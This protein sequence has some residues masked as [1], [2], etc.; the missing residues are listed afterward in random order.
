MKILQFLA[1]VGVVLTVAVPIAVVTYFGA[2]LFI[3]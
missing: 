3:S 1:I 2:I